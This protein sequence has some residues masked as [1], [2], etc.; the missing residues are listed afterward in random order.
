MSARRLQL[1]DG[2]SW[3]NPLGLRELQ[4]A[5]VWNGRSLPRDEKLEIASAP[6]R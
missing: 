1:D 4:D 5:L 3:H 2:A 6:Q